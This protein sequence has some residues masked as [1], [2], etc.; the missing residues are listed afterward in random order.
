ML[1]SLVSSGALKK[2]LME[3]NPDISSGILEAI[4]KHEVAGWNVKAIEPGIWMEIFEDVPLEEIQAVLKIFKQ[5]LALE[6]WQK[7]EDLK[8]IM[9]LSGVN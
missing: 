9:R 6:E 7:W 4:D 1:D 2:W 8:K 3:Q 5:Q